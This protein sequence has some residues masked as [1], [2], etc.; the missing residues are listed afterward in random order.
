[1]IDSINYQLINFT[2]LIQDGLSRFAA[3]GICDPA[4]K[5]FLGL[6]HWYKYLGGTKVDN[7][8]GIAGDSCVPVISGLSDI[9]LIVLAAVEILL[10]IVTLAAIGYVVYGGI[11]FITSR[12]NPEK[13]SSA[14]TAIQDAVIG[15]GIS[16]AAIA[17]VNFIGSRFKTV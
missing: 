10:R 16:I 11:R 13:S 15:L 3:G 4:E 9:W 6:P 1:M 14:R 8:G 5:N 17:I 7:G 12:G 2:L